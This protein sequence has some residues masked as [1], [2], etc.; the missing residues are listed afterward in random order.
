MQKFTCAL[1]KSSLVT[2]KYRTNG[3]WAKTVKTDKMT[4]KP[5]KLGKTDLVLVC[6]QGRVKLLSKKI[7][8]SDLLQQNVTWCILSEAL[9]KAD[10]AVEK[11]AAAL[12]EGVCLQDGGWSRRWITNVYFIL[13]F[14]VIWVL[15]ASIFV[16][17]CFVDCCIAANR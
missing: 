11:F 3:P 13:L 16:Y 14:C 4:Y 8:F 1:H 15:T 17:V 10:K 9:Y 7:Q 6:D 2:D 5:S 12:R